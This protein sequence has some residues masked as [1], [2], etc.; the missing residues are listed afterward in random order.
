LT[1]S[2]PAKPAR[3]PIRIASIGK[4]FTISAKIKPTLSTPEAVKAEIEM[5]AIN[6]AI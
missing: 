1:L 4:R 3:N 5:T 2:F 6:L